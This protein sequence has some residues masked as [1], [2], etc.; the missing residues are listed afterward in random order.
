MDVSPGNTPPVAVVGPDVVTDCQ[1][2]VT[3][4]GSH[5]SDPDG[6]AL[7]FEWTSA[8]YVLGTNSTLTGTFASGTNVVTLT[9]TDPSGASAQAS[10]TVAV[11]DT[12]APV[13]S[14]LGSVTL[15]ASANCQALL[16]NFL[17]RV[18]VSDNCTPVESINLQQAPAPGTTLTLGSHAVTITATDLAGNSATRTFT[19][20]VA[21]TTPPVII[22]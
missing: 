14:S 3:L 12:T 18:T 2:P 11:V 22:S 8:G 6:D 15:N 16:P 20:A 1:T 10:L 5:S 7:S 21:D 9:V 4:H 19:V 13:I 17:S